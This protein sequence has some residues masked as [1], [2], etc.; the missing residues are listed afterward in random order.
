MKSEKVR[1]RQKELKQ[2]RAD[3]RW[4]GGDSEAP[5]LACVSWEGS[6]EEEAFVVKNLE[7]TS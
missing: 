3:G 5:A 7:L 1:L 2:G 6:L 4:G